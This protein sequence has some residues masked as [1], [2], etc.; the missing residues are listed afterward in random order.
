MI[1]KSTHMKTRFLTLA[2]LL[3]L[4][5]QSATAQV[6]NDAGTANTYALSGGQ[7]LNITG[8][9]YTGTISAFG[10]GAVINVQAGAH[11][12]PSSIPNNAAGLINNFGRVTF[13]PTNFNVAAGSS[14][15][16]NNHGYVSASNFRFGAAEVTNFSAGRIYVSQTLDYAG[17][18]DNYGAIYVQGNVEVQGNG[19]MHN[20]QYAFLYADSLKLL[21]STDSNYGYTYAKRA[22]YTTGGPSRIVNNC[23]MVTSGGI[24]HTGGVI[25]NNGY[26]LALS[27]GFVNLGGYVGSAASVLQGTDFLNHTGGPTVSITGQGRFYFTGVTENRGR[28][29][30][31]KTGMNFYDASPTGLQTVDITTRAVDATVTRVPITPVDSSYAKN[32]C[33]SAVMVTLDLP[34][35]KDRP[36]PADE[37]FGPRLQLMQNPVTAGLQFTYRATSAGLLT[38]SLYSSA[39]S[40]LSSRKVPCSEGVN[41]FTLGA[42]LTTAKGIYLLEVVN[43]Q[44][45]RHTVKAVRL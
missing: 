23:T 28:M 31:D 20:R 22:I 34:A 12:A 21:S 18:I 32:Y 27:S 6:F 40:L 17:R 29:G 3:L 1:Q 9:T 8:G 35:K 33:N 15:K 30:E 37:K 36:V 41:G 2:A 14:L 42:Q 25:T 10:S 5:S 39:G 38:V 11:F 19:V 43:D 44:Q 45:Q 4:G 24:N 26:M 7:T 13:S 16:L